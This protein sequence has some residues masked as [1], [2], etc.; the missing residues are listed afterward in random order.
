MIILGLEV[1]KK[2]KFIWSDTLRLVQDKYKIP[3]CYKSFNAP[4]L[5][6]LPP[7]HDIA[8]KISECGVQLPT[9]PPKPPTY[10]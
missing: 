9:E 6:L 4:I 1:S 2:W 8:A 7:P 10:Y 5:Q 3:T